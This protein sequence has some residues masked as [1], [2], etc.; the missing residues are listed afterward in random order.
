MN[1]FSTFATDFTSN[2]TSNLERNN[3]GEAILL[4]S[5]GDE[6]VFY[7]NLTD[8]SKA[9]SVITSFD[10]AVCNYYK[11]NENHNIG[12]KCTSWL[13]GTPVANLIIT[14]NDK[15]IDFVGPSMDIG[16]R[17][18]KFASHHKFIISLDLAYLIAK[19]DRRSKIFYYGKETLKGVLQNKE[20]PI[21]YLESLHFE[22]HK[23]I[24]RIERYTQKNYVENSELC[25]FTE[26]FMKENPLIFSPFIIKDNQVKFGNIPKNYSDIYKKVV[27]EIYRKDPILQNDSDSVTNN[28]ETFNE[29]SKKIKAYKNLT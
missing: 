7:Y 28:R 4:K 17:I 10:D 24:N 5:L 23:K 2:F 3:C 6:L 16:F 29:V 19:N 20:Y 1:L 13:V 11:N 21:F 27:T 18:S 14:N 8:A 12:F 9:L 15:I 26:T 22:E 25:D